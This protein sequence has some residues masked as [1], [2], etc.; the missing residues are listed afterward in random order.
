VRIHL[1]SGG[2]SPPAGSEALTRALVVSGTAIALEVLPVE[3][4]GADLAAVADIVEERVRADIEAQAEIDDLSGEVADRYEELNLL[5]QLAERLAS[6]HDERDICGH[7]LAEAIRIIGGERSGVFLVEEGTGDL[8]LTAHHN[9]DEQGDGYR[10]ARGEGI[11][12]HVA[13]SGRTIHMEGTGSMP[14]EVRERPGGGRADLD[15]A[16]PPLVAVPLQAGASVQGTL[17]LTHKAFGRP[18]TSRDVKLARA[19]ATQAALFVES[20]RNLARVR[21][22]AR[23]QREIEIGRSIQQELLPRLEPIL[24]GLDVAGFSRPGAEFGGSFFGYFGSLQEVTGMALADVSGHSVAAAVMAATVRGILACQSTISTSSRE[25]VARV[26]DLVAKDLEEGGMFATLFYAVYE[27]ATAQ[28]SYTSAG[29]PPALLGRLAEPYCRRLTVGGPAIGVS[30]EGPYREET[31]SLIEGDV[32]VIHS[33]SL[34]EA[35]NAHG[36]CLGEERLSMALHRYRRGT[37]WEILTSILGEMDAFV[38]DARMGD[39]VTLIVLR[40]G[41]GS[42]GIRVKERLS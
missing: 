13:A 12:G 19:I 8:V 42:G 31:V 37:A 23:V 17:L 3:G 26:S 29:H 33:A 41:E 27:H 38:S 34:T 1:A 20:S 6:L 32:V 4:R 14:P 5:Y 7:I 30:G 40:A 21:E 39:D 24:P 35:K 15:V 36:E 9:L 22:G 10:L 28:L 18:F 25:I 11:L 16:S 2:I